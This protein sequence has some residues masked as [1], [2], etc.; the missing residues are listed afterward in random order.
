MSSQKLT[1]ATRTSTG[2][3]VSQPC[4]VYALGLKAEADAATV[5][6]RD[7]L[8][9]ALR[10]ALGAAIETSNSIAFDRGVRFKNGV[11]ITVTGTN[12][13]VFVAI[14]QPASSQI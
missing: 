6:F 12:P 13:N 3:I 7:G 2:I 8:N 9:G 1:T 10:W 14:E 5:E 11:H 4:V